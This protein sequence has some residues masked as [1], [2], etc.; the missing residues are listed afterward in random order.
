MASK[1]NLSLDPSNPDDQ[2]LVAD[3]QDGQEYDIT[4]HVIQTAPFRFDV[5]S[6]TETEVPTEE[7]SPTEGADTAPMG[8]SKTGNPAVDSMM[9]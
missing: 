9:K 6:A 7:V 3:W 5:T 8:K 2:A 1:R 4:V